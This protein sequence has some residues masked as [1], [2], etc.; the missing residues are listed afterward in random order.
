MWNGVSCGRPVDRVVGL[1]VSEPRTKGTYP[2]DT[3]HPP[4][5]RQP[6]ATPGKGA[7]PTLQAHQFQFHNPQSHN[8][9]PH[10]RTKV[11]RAPRYLPRRLDGT[12]VRNT[13]HSTGHQQCCQQQLLPRAA[14]SLC[15]PHRTSP[16][17]PGAVGWSRVGERKVK[18]PALVASRSWAAA[19]SRKIPAFPQ[20][21]LR[22]HCCCHISLN[23]FYPH[24]SFFS[25]YLFYPSFSSTN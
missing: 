17:L 2:V 6:R 21:P 3:G 18:I 8:P 13:G 4:F 19:A 5:S 24:L 12:L 23:I 11:E 16:L 14:V 15:P 9:A 25:Y 20:F 22:L 1:C 10:P 7:P